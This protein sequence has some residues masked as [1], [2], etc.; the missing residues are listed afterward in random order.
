MT[1][2]LLIETYVSYPARGSLRV[3][4]VVMRITVCGI[5]GAGNQFVVRESAL[6]R[7]CKQMKQ[8]TSPVDT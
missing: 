3:C 5:D 4:V 7:C 2:E 8:G 1:F 6:I